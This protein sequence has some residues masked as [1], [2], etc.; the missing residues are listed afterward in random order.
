MRNRDE[1][2]RIFTESRGL[3]F[4][5]MLQEYIPGPP[6]NHYFIE[7]YRDREG[8]FGALL[9]RRRVRMYPLEFGN[10]TAT[11]TI[12]L[13]EAE[14]AAQS[15]RLLLERIG[16]HGIFSAEFKRDD[17]DGLFKILEVNARPW[18]FVEFA[19]RSGVDVCERSY[20]E[21]L[22][23]HRPAV[24]SYE[25]G[26]KCVYPRRDLECRRALARTPH[27]LSMTSMLRFWAGADQLTMS[28]D[29]PSPGTRELYKSAR[30]RIRQLLRT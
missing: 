3:R 25:T 24:L 6:T 2:S 28:W 5:L 7:G 21:A 15:L 8:P 13:S 22:G 12:A 20:R 16:Y 27:P 26:R 23:E 14:P 30:S 4:N 11:K 9:A 1:L 29:D 10:S 17:R 19:A 18:W